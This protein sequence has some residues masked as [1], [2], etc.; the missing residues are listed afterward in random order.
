M[1]E[2]RFKEGQPRYMT[3]SI[4]E[5]VSIE[6]QMIL[7]GMVDALRKVK[8]LDYLQVFKLE[9]IGN[10][11]EGTLVQVIT[12]SQEQ[13]KYGRV[14][15]IP[16]LSNGVTGKIYIIDDG[17]TLPCY[18][19]TSIRREICRMNYLIAGMLTGAACIVVAELIW[20]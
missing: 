10:Q 2:E 7:W 15:Y 3:R 14:Y 5:E 9:T 4:S 17:S 11:E 1:K 8:K 6:I 13:P 20:A 18:G 16:T 19:Q 12:H